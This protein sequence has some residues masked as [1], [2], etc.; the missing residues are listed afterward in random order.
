MSSLK[1]NIAVASND[2]CKTYFF[3][4]VVLFC[5]YFCTFGTETLSG[6]REETKTF[7]GPHPYENNMDTSELIS[8]PGAEKL[9]K[10]F[11]A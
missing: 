3:V 10:Y 1:I 11:E 6:P 4:F 2:F 7:G 5:T 8:F 9:G